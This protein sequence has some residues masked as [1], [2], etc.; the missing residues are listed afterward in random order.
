MAGV[1]LLSGGLDS[2]VALAL[3]LE[4]NSLDVALTFDYGQRASEQEIKAAGLLARHYG[5]WHEVVELPF[6]QDQTRSALV[7]REAELPTLATE[8]LDDSQ[9][10]AAQSAH[11]VWVPNRNGLF[12]NIA[13]VYAEN[14]EQDAYL[15][16][17]FNREEAA[18]FADNSLEFMEAVNQS[19][20]YS[21]R[22]KITVVSPTAGLDKE[23]IV[24]AG[25]R[26]GV[27]FPHLWSCY[28]DAPQPCGQC[29]SCRR[30]QRALLRNGQ[31]D[32]VET[33]FR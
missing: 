28:A 24:R 17:G 33:M 26:L 32:L 27:P 16:A 11:H 20:R 13:A 2:A 12:L 7:N 4:H 18:T 23:E 5:L 25:L 22:Q 14:L 8:E 9:G 19:L 31:E 29:E 3:F 10:R 6:L 21:A 1:I 30:L 15:V